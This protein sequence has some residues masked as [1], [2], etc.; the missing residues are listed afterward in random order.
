M[1]KADR[2]RTRSQ[3]H[4]RLVRAEPG[5]VVGDR[6]L[7]HDRPRRRGCP[8]RRRGSTGAASP[9]GTAH[10]RGSTAAGTGSRARP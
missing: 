3:R 8:H 10:R 6:R 7:V 9:R 5:E 4:H 2:H 1:P